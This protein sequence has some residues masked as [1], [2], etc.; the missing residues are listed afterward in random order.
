MSVAR[1]R[2]S[3]VVVTGLGATTPLGGDAPTTW[4]GIVA[5]RSAARALTEPW[6]GALPVRIAARAAV[7]PDTVLDR[8]RARRLDRAARFALVAAEEA[9]ADAGFRG[10][11]GDHGQ[12][13]A[14]RVGVVL[15]SGIGGVGALLRA[16][17]QLR[18][19]RERAISPYTVPMVMVNGAAGAVSLALNARAAAHSPA[20]ACAAGAEAVAAGLDMIRLGRADVVAVGGSE[21]IIGP[22]TLTAFA[23]MHAVS[24]RND[25]PAGASR[26]YDK[27]R[28]GFVLGEGAA[29]LVLESAEHARARG[30]RVYCEL[31]GAGVSADA[32]HMVR[33]QP[34]GLGLASALRKALADAALAPADVAH[35]S[36]H[37]TSTPQGDIA[38]SRA[39]N[40]VLGES[41][42]AVSAVKSAAGHL[43]GGSGALG[44]LA[45]VMSLRDRTAPPVANLADVDDAIALDVVRTVPRALPAGDLAALSNA[46]GF[47]GHNVVL[48]FR[49]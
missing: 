33:P 36:A 11:A 47:G 29:V 24:R 37:A 32:H 30:A 2:L 40:H 10:P 19:G 20:G 3:E 26:P 48:A 22:L 6:A 25:D 8:T 14:E 28:D 49:S 44:A 27:Q 5:G 45:A 35:V 17:E 34:D 12:P 18:T 42:Y 23:S 46:A 15:G 7:E 13:P 16:Q 38:E 43:I 4:R 39:L 9:W 21:A 41:G 1:T 31:A